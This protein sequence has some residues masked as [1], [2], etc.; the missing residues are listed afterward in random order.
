MNNNVFGERIHKLRVDRKL[1]QQELGDAIGVTSTGVSY[2]ESGKAIPSMSM[3]KELSDFFCVTSDYLI[4]NDNPDASSE[5]KVLLRKAEQVD[6][7]D[8]SK[9]YDI[10]SGTIDTFLKNSKKNE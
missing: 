3:I 5:L 4:G 6:E 7:E 10:I 8:K 2:W 9:M 1:T